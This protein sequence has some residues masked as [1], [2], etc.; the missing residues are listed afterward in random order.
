MMEATRDTPYSKSRRVIFSARPVSY[1]I[2]PHKEEKS[3]LLASS[4]GLIASEIKMA[5]EID[6]TVN[7]FRFFIE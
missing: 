7:K 2:F 6:H 1:A 5:S 3:T 4:A